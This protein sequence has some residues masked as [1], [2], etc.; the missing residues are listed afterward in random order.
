MA[1]DT[2][3]AI[4]IARGVGV[5]RP[6]DG[7][8]DLP[9]ERTALEAGAFEECA[10]G[11]GRVRDR[12]RP[13]RPTSS[14]RQAGAPAR[15]LSA[16]AAPAGRRRDEGGTVTEELLTRL[17]HEIRDYAGLY[18]RY[19]PGDPERG[20]WSPLYARMRAWPSTH[21]AFMGLFTW[22]LRREGADHA[23]APRSRSSRVGTPAGLR[24]VLAQYLAH[25]RAPQSGR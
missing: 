3:H 24:A 15:R 4:Q 23:G 22:A 19:G 25:R 8:E 9:F 14:A 6:D 5:I 16:M 2:I 20:D 13:A 7:G 11:S 12:A 21:P 17:E 18:E 1:S 10:R